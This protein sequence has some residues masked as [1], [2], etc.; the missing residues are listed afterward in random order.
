[1]DKQMHGGQTTW[2]QYTP[3]HKHSLRGYKFHL[4]CQL[5]FSKLVSVTPLI[6]LFMWSQCKYHKY[7]AN[8]ENTSQQRWSPFIFSMIFSAP[9]HSLSHHCGFEPSSGHMWDKQSSAIGWSGGFYWGSPVLAP[10]RLTI[11]SA[12][13]EWNNLDG[14]KKTPKKNHH[15]KSHLVLFWMLINNCMRIMQ[16]QS[17]ASEPA[18]KWTSHAAQKFKVVQGFENV[19]YLVQRGRIHYSIFLKEPSLVCALGA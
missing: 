14:W 3:S 7:G 18:I 15:Y 13:N 17:S 6:M 2:K 5:C 8:S 10:P 19:P 12:Q 1:M 16:F 9:N 4:S 11:D